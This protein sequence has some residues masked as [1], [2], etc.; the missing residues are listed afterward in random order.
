[1][2]AP[3]LM[4][5]CG[6]GVKLCLEPAKLVF[7]YLCVL[8]CQ[9]SWH[10]YDAVNNEAQEEIGCNNR[11]RCFPLSELCVATVWATSSSLFILFPSPAFCSLLWTS[12]LL[13]LSRDSSLWTAIVNILQVY[14]VLIHCTVWMP[15]FY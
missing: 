15:Y 10:I 4:Y 6:W 5:A 11:Y 8:E 14:C 1:M 7:C 3:T 9:D 2:H 13:Q 12:L